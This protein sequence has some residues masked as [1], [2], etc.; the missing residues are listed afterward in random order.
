M[1]VVV[2]IR[3]ALSADRATHSD[4]EVTMLAVDDEADCVYLWVFVPPP[5][6]GEPADRLVAGHRTDVSDLPSGT[7]GTTRRL[8]RVLLDALRIVIPLELFRHLEFD[9]QLLVT[10][11]V[12]FV[13]RHPI[14]AVSLEGIG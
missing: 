11:F 2:L 8:C 9:I 12:G 7:S 14:I 4:H 10:E 3:S 1:P 13:I 6:A 5:A